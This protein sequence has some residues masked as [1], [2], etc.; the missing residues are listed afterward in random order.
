MTIFD[1]R[2]RRT[3]RREERRAAIEQWI[4]ESTPA[5]PKNIP[6]SPGAC[7]VAKTI[8]GTY[9][10]MWREIVRDSLGLPESAADGVLTTVHRETVI[11]T[12]PPRFDQHSASEW[13]AYAVI[14]N[15]GGSE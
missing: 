10:V 4:T 1:S 12:P 2:D 3:L 11:T 13:D 6:M 7:R 8:N 5:D 15:R 14:V 9:I